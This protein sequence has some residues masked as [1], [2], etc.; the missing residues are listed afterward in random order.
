MN[1][2]RRLGAHRR[3]TEGAEVGEFFNGCKKF[4]RAKLAEAPPL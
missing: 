2:C 1:E 4:P 3:D